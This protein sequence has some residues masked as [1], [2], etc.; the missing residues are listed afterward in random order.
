MRGDRRVASRVDIE[1][2]WRE[3]RGGGRAS[4]LARDQLNGRLAVGV[5]DETGD[6]SS[7]AE[8]VDIE[9]DGTIPRKEILAGAV[10]GGEL[11]PLRSF[12]AREGGFDNAEMRGIIFAQPETNT[13]LRLKCV[14]R[15]G[16][17]HR[18]Q[19]PSGRELPVPCVAE[20]GVQAARAGWG[21]RAVHAHGNE[22]GAGFDGA[23]EGPHE[24]RGFGGVGD[25]AALEGGL[26][27]DPHDD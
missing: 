2:V 7:V 1:R 12:R 4:D 21:K 6:D 17:N 16:P 9:E 5:E 27:A 8:R 19:A 10:G 23:G 11:Q 22:P 13:V 25:R 18:L 20:E 14:G 24:G 3:K 26:E 15:W